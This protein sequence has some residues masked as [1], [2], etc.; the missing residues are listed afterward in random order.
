M[1]RTVRQLMRIGHSTAVTLP[2]QHLALLGLDR[3]ALVE[4]RETPGG[5][6]VRP[7]GLW[8]L[9][10]ITSAARGGA[11]SAA[12]LAREARTS[13]A[14]LYGPRLRSIHHEHVSGRAVRLWIVLDRVDD[15][16]AELERTGELVTTW[17]VM[18]G[19]TVGRVFVPLREW[20]R[21]KRWFERPQ[22]RGSQG[23]VPE[24][25]G[26]SDTLETPEPP[27]APGV[28]DTLGTLD[29]CGSL[30]GSAAPART[31]APANDHHTT[32]DCP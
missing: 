29:T 6:L 24:A 3:G 14:A 28:R 31:G 17:S 21:W 10:A 1:E 4:I 19:L 9:P 12:A 30:K 27:E 7:V 26:T 8:A 13:L 22:T 15:Y 2:P 18:Y 16:A 5:L 11:R 23:Q 20:H 32:G 25:L